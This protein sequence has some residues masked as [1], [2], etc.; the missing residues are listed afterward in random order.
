[1]KDYLPRLKELQEQKR[2][3]RAGLAFIVAFILV[4]LILA[5]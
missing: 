3:D 4:M 1:M 5:L 2:I